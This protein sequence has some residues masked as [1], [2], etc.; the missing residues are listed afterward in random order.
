VT[1]GKLILWLLLIGAAVFAVE[2][3]EYSTRDLWNQRKHKL[4]LTAQTDSLAKVVDSLKRESHLIQTDAATQE[5]IAREQFG[6]VRG[7]K[8]IL[9]R[10]GSPR[11]TAAIRR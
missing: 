9:Y 1:V 5:R 11:D 3:G 7:D 2:G 8:E 4:E 6:M 10:L